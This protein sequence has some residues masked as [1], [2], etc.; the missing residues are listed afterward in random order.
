MGKEEG[1]Q[2]ATGQHLLLVDPEPLGKMRGRGRGRGRG[3][4]RGKMVK[5][6]CLKPHKMKGGWTKHGLAY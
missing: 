5:K 1:I 4:G 2:T 3:H 6:P